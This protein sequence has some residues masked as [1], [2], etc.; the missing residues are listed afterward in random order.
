M[1]KLSV[2]FAAVMM[3]VAV[4]VAK[5]QKM[6]SLDVASVLSVMPEKI[7]LD[8][9]MKTLSDT[10][11]A[12][13]EKKRTAAQQTFEKYQKEA[14]TQTQQINEQRSA[15]ME[16][17]QSNLQQEAM[18]GEK[19]IRDKYDAGLAPIEAKIKDAISKVAKAKGYD[20]IVDD[21]VFVYKGGPDATQDVKTQLGIK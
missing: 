14:S 15:E 18:A 1:K 19:D 4:G 13:L 12:E 17:L 9:Q 8:Q 20:F 6:A 10:K 16:K 5:A 7:K 11:K 3:F 21:T 2:L